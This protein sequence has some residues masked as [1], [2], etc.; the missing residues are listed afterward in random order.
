MLFAAGLGRTSPDISSGFVVQNAAPILY[1]SQL[2][3]LLN[4]TPCPPQN[5]Y[6]AGVTPGFAGLYQINLKLPDPLPPNPAIQLVIGTAASPPA[7][8][9][10]AQ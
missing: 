4:G 7:V 1:A 9:L 2:I 5:I 3:V 10:S 8:Q 6:Y